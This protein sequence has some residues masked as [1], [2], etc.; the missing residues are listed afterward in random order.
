MTEYETDTAI[1]DCVE[2]ANGQPGAVAA[3]AATVSRDSAQRRACALPAAA[4]EVLDDG[5]LASR[6]PT[7]IGLV[8]EVGRE[9]VVVEL[10]SVATTG[11]LAVGVERDGRREFLGVTERSREPAI[12]GVRMTGVFSGIADRLLADKSRVPRLDLET[13]R[14]DLPFSDAVYESWCQAGIFEREV[15]DRVLTCP[16]CAAVATFRFACRQ[17]GSGRLEHTTLMHHFAC[18][19]VAPADDF[20]DGEQLVCPNCRTRHLVAGTD[21]EYMPGDHA[22]RPCGWTDRDLVQTGHCLNCDRRFPAHQAIEQELVGYDAQRL[23]VLAL[24]ADLG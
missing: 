21:F 8:T 14:Y 19:F 10:N 15:L 24:T 12:T 5:R 16:K 20:D 17:C 6:T 23:D 13:F 22:C 1:L 11:L 9:S 4:W 3:N 18:A 2:L 7:G